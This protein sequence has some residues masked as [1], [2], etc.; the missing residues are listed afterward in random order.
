MNKIKYF[1]PISLNNLLK[2]IRNK[3]KKKLIVESKDQSLKL[4]S[5][6]D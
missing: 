4:Y 2:T 6:N 1:L 3:T 5:D